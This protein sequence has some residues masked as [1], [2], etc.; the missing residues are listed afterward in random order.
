MAPKGKIFAAAKEK[1][2]AK[3]EK[4]NDK[5][6]VPIPGSEFDKNLVKMAF[7]D[8]QIDQLTAQYEMLK[9]IIKEK[10]YETFLDVYAKSGGFPGS[11][12]LSSDSDTHLMF[13]PTDKYIKCDDVRATELKEAYGEDVI[14]EKTEYV[15]NAVLLDKYGEI[16][17]DFI[18]NCAEIAEDDK[19]EII[20]SKVTYG[21]SK[22]AIEKAFTWGKGL[23]KEFIRDIQPVFTSQKPKLGAKVDVMYSGA[24]DMTSDFWKK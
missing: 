15:F 24:T 16:F 10:G 14:T 6:N 7:L 5:L 11:F 18:E 9:G 17:S 23:V 12:I 2:A 20:Q 4:K 13:M 19:Y 1:S 22:G 21:V 8:A 3:A